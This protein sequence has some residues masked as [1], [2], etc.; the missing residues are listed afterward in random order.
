[1]KNKRY[2][3][4]S[5]T[6]VVL[7]SAILGVKYINN[8]PEETTYGEFMTEKFGDKTV[9]EIRIQ[10]ITPDSFTEVEITD[11][12]TIRNILDGPANTKL[13][14]ANAY[15]PH[16]RKYL[17]VFDS[18]VF[19]HISENLITFD[20]QVISYDADDDSVFRVIHEAFITNNN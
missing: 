18:S 20:G 16:D 3:I 9:K 5:F 13:K 15:R 10:E 2:I 12:Q 1:M 6:A 14:E 19:M 4:I 11:E 8:L 7:L 17:V